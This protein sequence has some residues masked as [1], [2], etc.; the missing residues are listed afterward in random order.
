MTMVLQKL[1]YLTVS[2]FAYTLE[3][4]RWSTGDRNRILAIQLGSMCI[5]NSR[6]TI[7]LLQNHLLAVGLKWNRFASHGPLQCV[8]CGALN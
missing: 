8:G 7:I 2:Q 4:L 1:T 6:T 5:L 3:V